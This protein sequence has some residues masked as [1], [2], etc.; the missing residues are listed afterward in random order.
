MKRIEILDCTL[1]DGG[2]VNDWNFG[3]LPS[4]E[5]VRTVSEAG[6]DYTELGFIRLGDYSHGKMQFTEMS[7][8][9]DLFRPS[10]NKLAIMVELGYGYSADAFP[11]HSE[12]TADLIRVT[13]WQRMIKQGLDYCKILK[14]KGY[15]V[16]VQ[17]TRTDQYS[18]D[19]FAE[20]I[21]LYNQIAPKAFYIVDT[22][23]L[24]DKDMLLSYAKIADEN[25]S[26]GIRIGYH[27]HNNMQQAVCNAIAFAEHEWQHNLIID[28]S[29]MGIGRGAGNLPEEVFFKYLNEKHGGSYRLTPL[30]DIAERYI[31]PIYDKTPWG[32]SIPY[33]LSAKNNCNPTYVDFFKSHGLTYTQMSR[34]FKEMHRQG[35]GIRY[36]EDAART[37][38]K[39]IL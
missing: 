20:F 19:E 38:M 28:A 33:L 6:V 30:Y 18:P 11:N 1:R 3:V 32:Y 36:D 23:G 22:F 4:K 26:D 29:V 2:Y 39:T 10:S 7:Q 35:I 15:E 24:M 12:N 5:I 17:A 21:Q 37:I 25:L 14:D 9:T 31:T 16:A 13:I 8:V 27:A 34:V